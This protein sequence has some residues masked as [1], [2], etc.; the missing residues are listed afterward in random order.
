[1]TTSPKPMT[2]ASAARATAITRAACVVFGV[3]AVALGVAGLPDRARPASPGV[4]PGM[5]GDPDLIASEGGSA[6][7]QVTPASFTPIDADAVAARLSMLENA[8][9]IPVVE[10]PITQPTPTET[11]PAEP[12]TAIASLADRVRYLGMISSGERRAA[13]LSIDGVQRILREGATIPLQ[14]AP[15]G[16]ESFVIDRIGPRAVTLRSGSERT[17]I[18]LAGRSGP[19]ITMIA[20]GEVERLNT[21]ASNDQQKLDAA[22]QL[23]ARE[24]RRLR[25][26]QRDRPDG[27][28]LN[29]EQIEAARARL[30]ARRTQNL[31]YQAEIDAAASQSG[32]PASDVD[33]EQPGRGRR[34]GGD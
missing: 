25:S 26:L 32:E 5:P 30:N 27:A 33:S 21:G 12:P 23:T 13:F 29:A 31:T 7:G 20:G 2:R 10:A 22:Q 1:M 24:E 6:T 18:N 17:D 19:S 11:K 8:P 28:P 16:A 15:P 4:P 34:R 3:G 14:N 9:V